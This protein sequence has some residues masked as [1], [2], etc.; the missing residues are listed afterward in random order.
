M[1]KGDKQTEQTGVP[2]KGKAI[3]YEGF[4]GGPF[5]IRASGKAISIDSMI[6]DLSKTLHSD[7]TVAQIAMYLDQTLHAAQQAKDKLDAAKASRELDKAINKMT[8]EMRKR[9]AFDLPVNF[10]VDFGKDSVS[11]STVAVCTLGDGPLGDN[12][13]IHGPALEVGTVIH[14][15]IN[16]AE[17][18]DQDSDLRDFLD[19]VAKPLKVEPGTKVCVPGF[20]HGV[21]VTPEEALGGTTPAPAKTDPELGTIKLPRTRPSAMTN[22]A[23]PRVSLEEARKMAQ[24]KARPTDTNPLVAMWDMNNNR[25]T[26]RMSEVLSILPVDSEHVTTEVKLKDRTIKV[27]VPSTAIM[28]FYDEY[29]ASVEVKGSKLDTVA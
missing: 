3:S 8:E 23:E 17:T 21:V 20:G 27:P 9:G 14:E 10:G 2:F 25:V 26:F 6:L 19:S 11:F 12:L 18:T 22:T 24:A 28:D 4:K 1:C 29:M 16:L 15:L 13:Y 7:V 5:M